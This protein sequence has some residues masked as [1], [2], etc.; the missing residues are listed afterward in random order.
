MII[1]NIWLPFGNLRSK[2]ITLIKTH[3]CKIPFLLK[4]CILSVL[5]TASAQVIPGLA[6]LGYA[7]L[8]HPYAAYPYGGLI[9]AAAAPAEEV[10]TVAAPVLAAPLSTGRV[11][12]APALPQSSQFQ[13]QD[14]FGNLAYGYANLN[15]AKQETGNTYGGVTG[16]Y[17]YTDSNG[18]VQTVNYIAD[19]LGFR[20]QA[21]NLPVA[22][23]AE[24]AQPVHEYELPVAPVFEGVQAPAPVHEYVLPVAPVYD[25]VA[26]APVE[27]T[28]EVLAAEAEHLA[29]VAAAAAPAERKRRSTP[30]ATEVLAAA[31]PLPALPYAGLGYAGALPYAGLGYAGALPHVAGYA[32]YPYAGLPYAGHGLAYAAPAVAAPL[33]A[34]PAAVVASAPAVRKA[35]KTVIQANPG[36]AEVYIVN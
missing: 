12:A 3:V 7:G 5:A 30:A 1:C 34:A 8:A 23:V 28:P 35:V 32:G 13:S 10:K 16:S 25:G 18:I 36:H 4:V 20:V 6:G 31:A 19:G 24:L 9:P 26:P 33:A 17:S 15:S 22:P 21:T 2:Y 14:E 29:A 27:K 11:I